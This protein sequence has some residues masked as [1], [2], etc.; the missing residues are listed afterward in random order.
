[1]VFSILNEVVQKSLIWGHFH[2]PQIK[3]YT[4][5]APLCPAPPASVPGNCW[6][7]LCLYGLVYPGLASEWSHTNTWPSV[8]AAPT[9]RNVLAANVSVLHS[10]LLPSNIPLLGYAILGVS[11]HPLM[12]IRVVSTI[13]DHREQQCECLCTNTWALV[14][15]SPGYV[16]R[17]GIGEL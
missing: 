6:S 9:W 11:V 16:I 1:M 7:P 4:C 10:F 17:D 5:I 3:P 2:F 15:S 13:F 14:F 8:P 12:D